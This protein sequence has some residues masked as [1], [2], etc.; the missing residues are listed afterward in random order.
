M[1]GQVSRYGI[2][3]VLNNLLSYFIYILLTWCWFDPKVVITIMYPI[4]AAI[5]YV[6]HRKYTFTYGGHHSYT[7]VRYVI[8]HLV[9][10]GTNI[11]LLYLFWNQ[12]GYPHQVVQ[13]LTVVFLAGVLFLLFR[14]F[15]FSERFQSS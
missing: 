9:G 3:G 7:L 15:V 14:Y 1:I 11:A 2:I 8:A 13:A 5:G 10:Y 6:G 4:A 12:L